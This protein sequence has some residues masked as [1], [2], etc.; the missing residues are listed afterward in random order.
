MATDKTPSIKEFNCKFRKK[1]KTFLYY[2]EVINQ[3]LT[4][5]NGQIITVS[6]R[7]SVI[8]LAEPLIPADKLYFDSFYL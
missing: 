4:L 5:S 8:P 6:T 2:I 1:E 7:A 3:T